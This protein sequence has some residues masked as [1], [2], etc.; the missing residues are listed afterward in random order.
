[1]WFCGIEPS[2]GKIQSLSADSCKHIREV[3]ATDCTNLP[4]SGVYCM[5]MQSVINMY[6]NRSTVTWQL[7]VE[8]GHLYSN[9]RT[10]KHYLSPLT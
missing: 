7:I 1:M 5:L 2:L 9:T 4:D 6:F 10:W 3:L 8:D